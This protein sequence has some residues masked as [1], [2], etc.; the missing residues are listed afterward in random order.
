MFRRLARRPAARFADA[1]ARRM[2]GTER[3]SPAT[4]IAQLS[5]MHAWRQHPPQLTDTGF[6]VFSQFEEDGLLLCI[7]TLIG[8]GSRRFVDIGS[9]DGINSNCANLALNHGWHGL[10]IDGNAALVEQGEAF[11][12]AHPDTWAWPSRFVHARITRENVNEIIEG[13]GVSGEVDLLSIDIDGNDYWVWDA[14][15]VIQ[16][17]V[18]IVE[19]HVQFGEHNIVVPYD[20]A[21]VYP[22]EHPDYNGAS[23]VAMARM[24]AGHGYRLVGANAYGFNTIYVR[25]G[26]GEDALP[27]VSVASTQRHPMNRE[28]VGA[29]DRLRHLA[30]VEGGSGFP[31]T[32]VRLD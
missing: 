21:Y 29:L 11:Y 8:M 30:Y 31:G 17:R 20:P 1:L 12:A 2:V 10:F 25:Q 18:V 9:A 22:G 19:T 5:L 26:E 16:P 24:A 7:F 14:L 15:G 6:R 3:W 4:K 27:E 23:P 32:P 28:A 13:A